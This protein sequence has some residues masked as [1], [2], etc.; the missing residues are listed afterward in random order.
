MLERLRLLFD[1]IFRKNN[2]QKNPTVT[3]LRNYS[4]KKQSFAT[5]LLLIFTFVF[6]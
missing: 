3:I 2:D 6:I 4:F 5:I 1:L